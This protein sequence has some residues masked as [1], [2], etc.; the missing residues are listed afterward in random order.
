[1]GTSMHLNKLNLNTMHGV[2]LFS[3]M[4]G[5]LVVVGFIFG[6]ISLAKNFCKLTK[7]EKKEIINND[8]DDEEEEEEEEEEDGNEKKQNKVLDDIET[9]DVDDDVSEGES[10]KGVKKVDEENVDVDDDNDD[11]SERESTKGLKKVNEETPEEYELRMGKLG[12]E[13]VRFEGESY[14]DYTFR[15][16]KVIHL[17]HLK[18]KRH[19]THEGNIISRR[20]DSIHSSHQLLK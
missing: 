1:M 7:K 9:E 2:S 4:V 15:M 14:E 11:V 12:K 19:H 3:I 5:G 8:D 17:H 16:E 13:Y 20:E 18:H 6:F 10:T